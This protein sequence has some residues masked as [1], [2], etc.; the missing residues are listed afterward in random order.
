[1]GSAKKCDKATFMR[2]DVLL[3]QLPGMTKAQPKEGKS[4]E[5]Q[6]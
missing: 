6:T 3:Q 4:L 1:V 2:A 5:P